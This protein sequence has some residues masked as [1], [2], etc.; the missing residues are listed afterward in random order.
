[1][2]NILITS[3]GKRVS[4]VRAFQKEAAKMPFPVKIYCCD[5][6]PEL[7]AA[8]Q[9]ADDHFKVPRLDSPDYYKVLIHKCLEADIKLII[10]TIDTE[11]SLLAG[12]INDL[13]SNNI[14]PLVS[15]PEFIDITRD[16]RK[17]HKFFSDHSVDTAETYGKDNLKFPL[18]IKP[19]DG[20]RSVGAYL[21]R[22]P[23]ELLPNHLNNEKNMFLEYID[24]DTHDEFTCD[25]YYD[26]THRLRCAIPR[27]RIAVRD[28]EVNK[29]VTEKNHLEKEIRNKLEVIPG[30]KGCLTAQFFVN[31]KTGRIIGNEIN[32]R[33]GGGFPLSYLAGGNFPGWI[34]HE[35][36]LNEEISDQFNSWESGLLMLRYDHE[37]LVHDYKD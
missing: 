23:S 24:H 5:A 15:D 33:F 35:Y 30:A 6:A 19:Y 9:I 17:M 27:K 31:K 11:L 1:M 29:G 3:A 10:P 14:I 4:L 28:G 16:K 2:K 13:M 36:L 20:S 8:C 21:I 18:F 34:L 12:H 32:A 22:K 25:L 37:V 26:K 7:S